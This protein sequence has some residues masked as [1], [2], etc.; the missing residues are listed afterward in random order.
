[1]DAIS[2]KSCRVGIL[3]M[4]Y[5][6][7]PMATIFAKKGFK[8]RGG[9]I[10]PKI[11]DTINRG[12]SPINENGIES[13]VAQAIS[14]GNLEATLDT[15][16]VAGESDVILVVVQTPIDEEKNPNLAALK[17]AISTISKNLRE[18]SLIIIESTLPPG[19]TEGELVPI[20]EESGLRAGHDFHLAYSPERAIPTKTIEEIQKNS[21]IVGGITNES[22]ELAMALYSQITTGELI[23]T[24]IKTAEMVKVIENTFRDVNIALSNEIAMLCEKLGVDAMSAIDMANKHPRVNLLR[25]GT[26]VGGH[27]IP[28]D[29]HFLIGK[30]RELGVELEVITSARHV[31]ENMP[32]H[33]LKMIERALESADKKIEDSKIAILG[34]AYKGDTD[35]TRETPAKEVIET[36]AR[37]KCDVFSHDPF[38]SQDFGKKFS[39]NLED[40]ARDADC[41]V[42]VTDHNE[43]RSLDLAKLSKILKKPGVIVDGRRIV[44]PQSAAESDFRYFGVGY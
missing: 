3:G 44:D 7:L 15:D 38:V 4:G 20:L 25:P 41:L 37:M 19:T 30:A 35:D 16:S 18:G 39:N 1:M 8:V 6:G 28:K 5:V 27:C 2:G 21:R 17:S 43:Y 14:S 29:P 42:I 11:V 10:N 24:D 32:K 9:D 31:N 13:M 34:I 22:A 12:E 33:L 23:A 36:L 40:A 26:G